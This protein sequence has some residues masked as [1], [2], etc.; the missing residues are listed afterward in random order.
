MFLDLDAN[1]SLENQTKPQR[2]LTNKHQFAAKQHLKSLMPEIVSAVLN[3]FLVLVR[4]L[5]YFKHLAQRSNSNGRT[6]FFDNYAFIKFGINWTHLSSFHACGRWVSK[7]G[8]NLNS[9]GTIRRMEKCEQLISYGSNLK[10]LCN[11]FFPRW[12]QDRIGEWR[13]KGDNCKLMSC[14][15]R[16]LKWINNQI[17]IAQ[18]K[19]RLF[20]AT[21][22]YSFFFSIRK[23]V[24]IW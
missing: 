2:Q 3:F 6:M 10:Q 5:Q 1:K 18:L 7:K 8:I 20:K 12:R 17:K 4:C 22:K 13:S 21:V 24:Q 23:Y 19:F 15:S 16:L 11:L 14:P 9:F